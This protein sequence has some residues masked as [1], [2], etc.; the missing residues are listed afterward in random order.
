MSCAILGTHGAKQ[1]RRARASVE[2]DDATYQGVGLF[3]KTIEVLYP[4]LLLLNWI[5]LS[6]LQAVIKKWC[7]VH[8]RVRLGRVNVT[9]WLQHE[10]HCESYLRVIPAG[11]YRAPVRLVGTAEVGID[12]RSYSL[13]Y[14]RLRPAL[15][16]KRM[17][18]RQ[19]E[20]R[21]MSILSSYAGRWDLVHRQFPGLH[22]DFIEDHDYTIKRY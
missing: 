19:C 15:G 7:E 12:I 5:S 8:G 18:N 17:E 20:W 14:I 10:A 16:R 21:A 9:W 4:K 6:P 2:S 11:Y 13:P 22:F 1:L 3:E